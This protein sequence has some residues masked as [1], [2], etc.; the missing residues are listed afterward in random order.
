VF[1]VD[2][3]LNKKGDII[4]Y[5]DLEVHTGEKHTNMRFFLMD[6]GPQ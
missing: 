4:F 5:T 1:N 2:G 3:T 6:L